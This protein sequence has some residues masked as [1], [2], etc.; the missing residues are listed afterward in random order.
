[1]ANPENLVPIPKGVSLNPAGRKKGER[2]MSTILRDIMKTKIEM[3]DPVLKK[4]V[5]QPVKYIIMLK[6]AQKA[7]KG[8]LKAIEI[9]LDRTEGKAKQI[10]EQITRNGDLTPEQLVAKIEQIAEEEGLTVDEL[11]RKE[12]LDI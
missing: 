11:R 2:N 8:D 3:V 10:V 6:L 5:K 1:M 7:M 12:G 4:K 9:M